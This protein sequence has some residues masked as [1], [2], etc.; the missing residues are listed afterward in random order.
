MSPLQ[1]HPALMAINASAA[2]A[3]RKDVRDKFVV[4]DGNEI[5]IDVE[6]TRSVRPAIRAVRTRAV[7]SSS[8]APHSSPQAEDHLQAGFP[9]RERLTVAA[10]RA[11][12]PG[13][14][15]QLRDRRQHCHVDLHR[16][17]KGAECELCHNIIRA[18]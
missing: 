18:P 1:R 17:T 10:C 4:P 13:L 9:L 15:S 6:P 8:F 12:L 11:T 16:R 14:S 5:R 7:S 2:S 3:P